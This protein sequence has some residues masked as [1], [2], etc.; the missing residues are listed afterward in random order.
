M[1]EFT[2]AELPIQISIFRN[3]ASADIYSTADDN[4]ASSAFRR[5]WSYL[6]IADAAAPLTI[7][8]SQQQKNIDL[9]VD[10][11]C[12]LEAYI[13]FTQA[14]G[15][16]AD[17]VKNQSELPRVAERRFHDQTMRLEGVISGTAPVLGIGNLNGM[18][19]LFPCTTH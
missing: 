17:C 10:F 12:T 11:E 15:K 3:S 5:F 9:Q 7:F 6:E 8:D 16:L 18:P 2:P 1:T 13:R 4:E 19:F 14:V